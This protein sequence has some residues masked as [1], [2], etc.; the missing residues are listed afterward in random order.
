MHAYIDAL[1][2]HE[3]G[4]SSGHDMSII[5]QLRVNFKQYVPT[6]PAY[7]SALL[8]VLPF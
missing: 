3:E 7:G 4:Q 8:N 6:V 5:Y 1:M 2:T